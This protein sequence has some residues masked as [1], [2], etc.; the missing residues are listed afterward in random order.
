[1]KIVEQPERFKLIM[2]VYLVLLRQGQVLLLLRANTGYEDGNYSLI[3]GHVDGDE[4]ARQAMVREAQEEAGI[5]IVPDDL[6]LV[7]V[8]HRRAEDERLAIF[9]TT[10]RWQGEPSNCEP[11]KCDDMGWFG[12]DAMPANMV[13]YVRD[14][15]G[16]V[17]RGENYSEPGW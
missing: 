16:Q 15:I 9:F 10:D 17:Q 6:R 7:H 2:E 14:I 3:A 11:H 12:L 5:T 13:G 8:A 4:T 1:M